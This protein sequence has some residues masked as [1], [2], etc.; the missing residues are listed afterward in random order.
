MLEIVLGNGFM[1][2]ITGSSSYGSLRLNFIVDYPLHGFQIALNNAVSLVFSM[3]ELNCNIFVACITVLNFSNSNLVFLTA[4][5]FFASNI[6]CS[7]LLKSG[8]LIMLSNIF[9]S[10][11]QRK[12]GMT[13]QDHCWPKSKAQHETRMF[14]SKLHLI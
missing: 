1:F 2:E 5:D 14:M 6:S 4:G 7:R 12:S 10:V 13:F 11:A 9:L 3:F 8:K